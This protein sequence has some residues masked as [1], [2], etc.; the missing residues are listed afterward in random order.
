MA[1][2]PFNS[3]ENSASNPLAEI[4]IHHRRAIVSLVPSDIQ[5]SPPGEQ[6]SGEV[7]QITIMAKN[8]GDAQGDVFFTIYE[9]L[10]SGSTK[11]IASKN[12]TIP[13]GSQPIQLRY[14][15]VP[16]ME[17]LHYVRVE[18]G[19]QTIEGPF[20]EVLPPRATG[21]NAVFEDTNPLLVVS[22]VGLIV[23]VLILLVVV[24]RKV[25]MMNMS[26]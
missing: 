16:N 4:P 1:G 8:I 7:I 6:N 19:E 13:L 26:G 3:E 12:E 18:W 20:I 23:A 24:L 2:N 14:E 21:L 17:G 11:T 15:W 25:R 22:F 5:Y 9:V 10:P